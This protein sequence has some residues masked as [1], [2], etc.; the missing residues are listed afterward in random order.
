MCALDEML[1]LTSRLAGTFS[2]ESVIAPIDVMISDAIMIYQ[3]NAE[4]ISNQVFQVAISKMS[5][6]NKSFRC[7]QQMYNV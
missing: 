3:E 1:K 4:S 7:M 2:I 5:A 6:S